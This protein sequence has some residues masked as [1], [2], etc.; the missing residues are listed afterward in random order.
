MV[1]V[2]GNGKVYLVAESSNP[3]VAPKFLTVK[4]FIKDRSDQLDEVASVETGNDV[5]L[6]VLEIFCSEV[7]VKPK[8]QT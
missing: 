4:D 3:G 1:A 7:I 8:K 6:F 2:G 5:L